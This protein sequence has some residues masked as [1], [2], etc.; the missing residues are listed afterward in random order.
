MHAFAA[1]I[2][3]GLRH[4]L[5]QHG[6]YF[7][8]LPGLRHQGAEKRRAVRAEVALGRNGQN[9]C[10]AV[11]APVH[12]EEFGFEVRARFHLGR[13]GRAARHRFWENVNFE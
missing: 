2:F 13:E 6:N 8:V 9:E 1:E 3:L 5:R 11:L 7:D 10:A 4:R 12:A